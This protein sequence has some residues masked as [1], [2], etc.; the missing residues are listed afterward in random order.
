MTLRAM[1]VGIVVTAVVAQGV[2]VLATPSVSHADGPAVLQSYDTILQGLEAVGWQS[3]ETEAR[4]VVAAIHDVPNDVRLVRW[5]RNE[6]RSY[7]FGRLL[8]AIGREHR[9]EPLTADEQSWLDTL[10]NRLSARRIARA[11]K[12][13]D[14]LDRFDADPCGYQPPDGFGFARIPRHVSCDNPLY[15]GLP[16]APPTVEQFQAY[17]TA[18]VDGE[19]LGTADAEAAFRGTVAYTTLLAGIYVAGLATAILV[20]AAAALP[21]F[22]AAAAAAMGSTIAAIAAGTAS[23]AIILTPAGVAAA[24][25]AVPGVAAG[26]LSVVFVVIVAAVITGIA[27]WQLIEAEQVD[28][29]LEAALAQAQNTP[30]DLWELS[31]GDGRAEIMTSLL[32][33]TLS[34]TGSDFSA[35]R[36]AADSPDPHGPDDPDFIAEGATTPTSVLPTKDWNGQPQE[37]Y[38]VGNWFVTR[39][40]GADWEWDLGL[41]HLDGQGRPTTAYVRGEGFLVQRAADTD[42]S[43][44]IPT[45]E[46]STLIV[47]DPPSS[48]LVPIPKAWT[49]RHYHPPTNAPTATS[50]VTQGETVTLIA[51]ADDPDGDDVSTTWLVQPDPVGLTVEV[52]PNDCRGDVLPTNCGWPSYEG[53]Q[54]QLPYRVPGTYLAWAITT[55]GRGQRTASKVEFTVGN[56]AP[57]FTTGPSV[58]VNGR[59]ATVTGTVDDPGTSVTVG[60]DWGD[61]TTSTQNFP[62]GP[63]DAGCV[64]DA[65]ATFDG[66]VSFSFSHT[67]DEPPPQGAMYDV[68]VTVADRDSTTTADAL[69]VSFAARPI[70]APTVSGDLVEGAVIT[71]DAGQVHGDPQADVTVEWILEPEKSISS[72]DLRDPVNDALCRAATG[73]A[74]G[75]TWPRSTANSVQ[76]TYR[77]E[78]DYLARLIVTDDTGQVAAAVVPFTVTN[79]PPAFTETPRAGV[80]GRQVTVNG[81]FGDPGQDEVVVQVDWGDGSTS[82]RRFACDPTSEICLDFSPAARPTSF[83]FVHTYATAVPAGFPTVSLDDGTVTVGPQQATRTSPPSVPVAITATQTGSGRVSVGYQAPASD[84]G[85][86]ITS[87]RAVCS[88]VDG[89]TARSASGLSNP[90]VLTGFTLG[91]TYSCRMSATN[92]VGT[93]S[94]SPPSAPFVV[95]GVPGAPS[96]VSAE[97]A[98]SQRLRVS[99]TA[100]ASDGGSP[101]ISYRALCT[102]AGGVSRSASGAASPLVVTGLSAGIAYACVVTA[103][104]AGGTGPASSPSPTR[105]S[106]TTPAPPTSVVATSPASVTGSARLDVSFFPPMPSFSA[107]AVALGT[108]RAMCT[109]PAGVTRS[110]SGPSSPLVVSGLTTG[111][112]YSCVVTSSNPAGTSIPSAPSRAIRVVGPPSAPTGVV[113]SGVGARQATLSFAA[114]ASN[115]GS[116]IVSYRAVCTSSSG[117]AARSAS[118]VA[119]PIVVT[120][121]SLGATYTCRVSAANTVGTSTASAPSGSFVAA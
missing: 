90:L 2:V 30:P 64:L 45:V 80:V 48:I 50:P 39:Q 46:T 84:G 82:Q 92:S 62:C 57:T 97:V 112:D 73:P 42:T 67:F 86:P 20:A 70:A 75:C 87:Y 36:A 101:I 111:V 106:L 93:G 76:R 91:A 71:F 32:Q 115:G 100:P 53:E 52:T 72:L 35:Q 96:G 54:L 59:T 1:V 103:T 3:L 102:G 116:A 18:L 49:V 41:D 99:F 109:S 79:A 81:T 6:I 14:E 61:G 26:A 51:N 33:A 69:P 107:P 8:E 105:T 24:T 22:A 38:I 28:D 113:V 89:G 104:N 58:T 10:R 119:G 9:G 66:P 110:A 16:Q 114:P 95:V 27:L 43:A 23:S 108:F 4:S 13:L 55:D 121:L 40:S 19:G 83:G 25:A 29:R 68:V 63:F 120:G 85:M 37:S 94:T 15:V 117:G 7:M 34:P 31:Q 47:A 21:A 44:A 65:F 5:A 78:G 88:S 17:A 74:A 98:G 56:V 12:A 60:V 77:V 11:E 118:N